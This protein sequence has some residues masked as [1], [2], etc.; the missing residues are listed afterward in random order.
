M[1]V[2]SMGAADFECFIRD[3]MR[4]GVVEPRVSV[5]MDEL[6]EIADSEF[7][8]PYR[9]DLDAFGFDYYQSIG[10]VL[11]DIRRDNDLTTED[12]AWVVGCKPEQYEG[13][14]NT[15]YGR[16]IPQLLGVRI[17][18]G[19]GVQDSSIFL[20]YMDAYRGFKSARRVQELR[21][22]VLECFD[23][24]ECAGLLKYV[25]VYRERV[26]HYRREKF[27]SFNRPVG[28]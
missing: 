13:F 23:E 14:E 10:Q 4:W 25:K 16:S 8:C 12:V 9:L 3:C 28:D 6:E 11:V 24:N 5:F 2:V 7:A 17:I 18:V 22:R 26:I 21:T 19:L 15:V 20:K 1:R 27:V